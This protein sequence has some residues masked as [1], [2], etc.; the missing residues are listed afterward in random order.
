MSPQSSLF[1]FEE[2]GLRDLS[3]LTDAEREVYIAVERDGTPVRQV[4]RATDRRPGTVG[5]LLKR[6]RL[7]LDDRDEEVADTW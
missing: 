7:R 1:D 4:A 6:A 5:N 3:E 2:D